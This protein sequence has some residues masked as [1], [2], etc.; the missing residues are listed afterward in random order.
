M[1]FFIFSA[2]N[3]GTTVAS[4]Y[5]AAAADA[6]LPTFGNFE[7]QFVPEVKD[8]MRRAGW[9]PEKQVDFARVK[10]VWDSYL[11]RS[12]KRVFVE[13]SPDNLVRVADIFDVFPER[14][15]IFMMA[16]P[17]MQI[18]SETKNY[19][20]A[21]LDRDKVAKAVARWL[22]KARCQVNNMDRWPDVP[23]LRY[24]DFCADPSRLTS[25]FGHYSKAV[26][27]I[28]GKATT[29]VRDVRDMS[30]KTR[31]FLTCYE[32]AWI[33]DALSGETALLDRLGYRVESL[34]EIEALYAA[35]PAQTH[36]GLVDRVRWEATPPPS[37]L[38]SWV[39]KYPGIT[40]L[41]KRLGVRSP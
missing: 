11:D 9:A 5:L 35:S 25:A 27:A 41:A 8:E 13:A 24:E 34:G 26:T 17:F 20:H 39:K 28:A 36:A 33:S 3:S 7:G 4:Q 29:G 18:A 2:N 22:R 32:A 14:K 1:Y 37:A 23:Y 38:R 12:G 21:P 6:Y 31:S 19:F 15:A 40:R 16:S 30:I 10:L